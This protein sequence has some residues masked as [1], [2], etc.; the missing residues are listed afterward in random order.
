LTQKIELF[1][2]LVTMTTG[3]E[4]EVTLLEGTRRVQCIEN[5][6]FWPHA[7]AFQPTK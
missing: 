2:V 3:R 7:S 5:G 6:A 4:D 1:D